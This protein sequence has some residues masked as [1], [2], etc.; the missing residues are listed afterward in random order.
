M[1][2]LHNNI[3]GTASTSISYNSANKYEITVVV[4]YDDYY[5]DDVTVNLKSCNT[6][7]GLE[8]YC[9]DKWGTQD[10]SVSTNSD[11]VCKFTEYEKNY[12]MAMI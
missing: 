4:H 1:S 12:S 8:G 7:L 3:I 6:I 5:S 10:A 2:S 9:D 11:R